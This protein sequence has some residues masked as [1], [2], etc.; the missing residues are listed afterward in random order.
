ML[1]IKMDG[2]PLTIGDKVWH[3]TEG[4]GTV[5]D[6][7]ESQTQIS[8]FYVEVSFAKSVRKFGYSWGGLDLGGD[9]PRRIFWSKPEKPPVKNKYFHHGKKVDFNKTLGVK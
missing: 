6:I 4:E 1:E 7:K 5:T 2:K 8:R 9:K 3:I